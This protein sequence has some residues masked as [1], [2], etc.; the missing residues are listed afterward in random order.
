MAYV[1][2]RLNFSLSALEGSNKISAESES[3]GNLFSR[4]TEG[5]GDDL[6]LVSH[7]YNP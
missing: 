6:S 2:L 4:N 7:I 1:S 3:K 5:K